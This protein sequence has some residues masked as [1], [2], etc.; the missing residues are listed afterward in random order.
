MAETYPAILLVHGFPFDHEQ[1]RPQ[2][3]RLTR[4][5]CMAPDLRGF[6]SGAAP[7]GGYSMRVY[8]DDLVA[9][10]D[11]A[12]IERAVWCGLS[13]GGYILFDVLRRHPERVCGVILCD[14]KAEPDT[15]EGKAGRDELA[16]VA[17]R[18]GA[19]AIA[20]RLL[21]KLLGATTRAQRPEVVATVRAMASRLLVP[22]LVGALQAMRERPDSGPVLEQIRVPALVLG[23]SEDEISPAAGMRAMAQRIRGARYEEVPDAGHLAP[24]ERPELVNEAL[25]DFLLHTSFR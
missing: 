17:E 14:T 10:L 11:A 18:E 8:A 4:W 23:G 12:G 19:A 24:L 2:L 21:P 16:R 20:E 1:W 6:T 13:M 22:G 7:A 9:V 15:V 3:A 5:R 25:E